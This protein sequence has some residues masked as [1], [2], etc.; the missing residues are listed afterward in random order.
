VVGDDTLI[1]GKQIVPSRPS[2]E[3]RYGTMLC[4]E[5]GKLMESGLFGCIA[6]GKVSVWTNGYFSNV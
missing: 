6:E 2:G 1:T 5:E 4:N 3:G